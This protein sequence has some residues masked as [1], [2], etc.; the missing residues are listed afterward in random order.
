MRETG[1]VLQARLN[2]HDRYGNLIEFVEEIINEKII[3]FNKFNG[4]LFVY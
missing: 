4:L 3:L 2:Y 1:S